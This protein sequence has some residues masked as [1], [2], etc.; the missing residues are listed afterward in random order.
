MAT[1]KRSEEGQERRR[2]QLEELR[3]RLVS[4]KR[5]SSMRDLPE[6]KDL[7]K[8]LDSFCEM[9]KRKTES[10][11][12]SCCDPKEDPRECKENLRVYRERQSCFELVVDLVENQEEKVD[13]LTTAIKNVENQF[14][15]AQAELA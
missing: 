12:I 7:K 2:K 5:L 8:V 3:I 9:E 15:E 4:V 11:V 6:W 14:K 10:A 13:H 1:V